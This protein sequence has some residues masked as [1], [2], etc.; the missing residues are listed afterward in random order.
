[1]VRDDIGSETDE[2]IMGDKL[3]GWI[4]KYV[5]TIP[6]P[7]T[8]TA[9]YYPFKAANIDVNKTS[10]MAGWYN[11]NIEILPHVKFEGMDV[12]LKLET[13]LG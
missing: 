2:N 8:L 13:R 12:T 7:N 3:N 4:N 11:C 6:N 5:T 1:M 9:T 10:G